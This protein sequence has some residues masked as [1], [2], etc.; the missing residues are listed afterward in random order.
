MPV[1]IGETGTTSKSSRRYVR[2]I[3]GN[4]DVRELQKTSESANEKS[5]KDLTW[6]ITLHV[7]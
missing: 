2:Y 7:S 5:T 1:T 4:H 6:E 3:P